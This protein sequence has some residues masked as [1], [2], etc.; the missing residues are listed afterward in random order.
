MPSSSS[1]TTGGSG[2]SRNPAVVPW[3]VAGVM[4]AGL[5]ASLLLGG[6]RGGRSSNGDKTRDTIIVKAEITNPVDVNGE[7]TSNVTGTVSV[8]G[9]VTTHVD[10]IDGV[11]EVCN[12]PCDSSGP[13]TSSNSHPVDTVRSPSSTPVDTVG[14]IEERPV[15]TVRKSEPKKCTAIITWTGPCPDDDDEEYEEQGY[16]EQYESCANWFDAVRDYS[17]G[18][19]R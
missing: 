1:S 7:V 9:T 5:I 10:G 13:K 18:N 3:C 8:A 4:T 6:N 17:R 12:K 19:V 14:N 15:D 2:T 16:E 11:V